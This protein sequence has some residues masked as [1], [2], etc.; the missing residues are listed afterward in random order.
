MAFLV[1]AGVLW[2]DD[3]SL[4]EQYERI[5]FSPGL[6]ITDFFSVG[7]IGASLINAGLMGLLALGIIYYTKTSISGPTF[8]IVFTVAG[9]AMF[10]KTPVN[11]WPIPLGVALSAWYRKER[12][13][14]FLLA[15]LFGTALG[16]VVSQIAFGLELGYPVGV[17]AGIA[18]GVVLPG[19]ASHVLHNHQGFCLYNIGFTCGILGMFVTAMLSLFG[20]KHELTFAWHE[21][22]QRELALLFTVYF[23]S[24]LILGIRGAKYFRSVFKQVGSLVTDF[25]YREGIDATFFN[26]GLVGLLGMAY[27]WA[28]GGHFNGPTLGAVMT[29]V[30]FAAFGKHPVNVFPIMLGVLLAALLSSRSPAEPAVLLG[31]LFG[32]TLAPIAGGFGIIAGILAGTIHLGVVLHV[33][34][35]HGGMNLYN[36]GFAGGLVATL[37]ICTIRWLHLHRTSE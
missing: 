18:C 37:F 20:Y 27:I 34:S 10:G 14:S 7:G 35:F 25:V 29:M 1:V 15:A 31:A 30:G 16:P 28:V 32:T 3:L 19:L 11:V 24:M 8:A 17:G 21:E 22:S 26:M 6:L 9:F 23:S 36:N 2:P 33:G 4:F 13:R 12:F 5:L